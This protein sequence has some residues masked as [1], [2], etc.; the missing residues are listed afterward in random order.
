MSDNW[1]RASEIGD[2]LYC[3]RSWWLKRSRGIAP[4][5]VRELARGTQYH[6][7]HGNLVQQ[8]IWLRRAAYVLIFVVV[9]VVTYSLVGG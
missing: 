9:A 1:I 4:E 5:N 3:R 8:S 7:Q 2:Y 6:R